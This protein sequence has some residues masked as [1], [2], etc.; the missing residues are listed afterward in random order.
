MILCCGEALIDMIPSRTVDGLDS[1]VP[2]PGGS[3]YNTA[4][5]LGRL[6]KTAGLLTGL[7]SDLF[8][9]QLRDALTKSQVDT[10]HIVESDRPTT[11]A[12]VKMVDGQ[13]QYQFY[14]EN[15]AAR[16]LA[17]SDMPNELP[18]V[19]T[20]FFGGISL[21]CYPCA[22]AYAALLER[23]GASRVVM[24][25]P[26]IRAKFIQDEVIY[27][28]RLSRL[29]RKVTILKVSDEDLAWLVP[30]AGDDLQKA[31]ILLGQG[32]LLVV[33][34]KGEQG[35]T[36]YLANGLRVTVPSQPADTVDTV[37]AG[38]TFNAG[39]LAFLAGADLLTKNE[40]A[41]LSQ[42]AL[43]QALDFAARVAAITVS[44]A[45]ANPPWADEVTLPGQ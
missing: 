18:G 42:N 12:F 28:A 8:G 6:G 11:L 41:T 44:R 17:P 14:D 38:D 40:I 16:M 20:L 26:N 34:T 33:V 29:M 43:A 13:A 31:S 32:P 4:I 21:A 22:E 27:R 30:D 1:F 23:Q 10:S 2:H 35:A 5:A 19:N 7:S 9:S 3:V 39:L 24:L 25:D 45:G 36:A 15:S 37:G